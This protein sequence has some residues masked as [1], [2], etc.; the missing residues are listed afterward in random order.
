ML[1]YIDRKGYNSGVFPITS[2][3]GFPDVSKYIILYDK[4][5]TITPEE[6]FV[7]NRFYSLKHGLRKR[8][9]KS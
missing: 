2:T 9:G 1:I 4:L 3:L 7:F 8:F 6:S 5:G